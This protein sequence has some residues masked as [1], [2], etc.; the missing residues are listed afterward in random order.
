M[1]R[2]IRWFSMDLKMAIARST[3]TLS[4]FGLLTSCAGM[5]PVFFPEDRGVTQSEELWATNQSLDHRGYKEA[6]RNDLQ[7][8]FRQLGGKLA[9]RP[10]LDSAHSAFE[11]G[12]FD[13][14]RSLYLRFLDAFPRHPLEDEAHYF[15]GLSYFKEMLD[16]D[17]DQS[18]THRALKHFYAVL[19]DPDSHYRAEV[20][21]NIALCRRRLAEKEIYVGTFYFRHGRYVAALGRFETILHDYYGIGLDDQALFYKGEALRKLQRQ[22]EARAAFSHLLQEYPGS[23]VAKKAASRLCCQTFQMSQ[24]STGQFYNDFDTAVAE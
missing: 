14:A 5:Q 10:L 3:I 20:R 24:S 12:E 16:V 23:S 15:L 13:E 1:I 9:A 7:E 18:F 19:Q 4:A 2:I 8:T 22:E 21:P 17:L 6:Q 11:A